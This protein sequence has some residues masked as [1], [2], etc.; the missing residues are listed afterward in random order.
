MSWDL[1][2]VGQLNN[3]HITTRY[4]LMFVGVLNS[5]GTPFSIFSDSGKVQITQRS[6][7]IQGTR[8]RAQTWS[9][10]CILILRCVICTLPL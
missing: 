9:V 1:T 2:F 7:S 10:P 3:N 6:I 8:I 5:L 4:K